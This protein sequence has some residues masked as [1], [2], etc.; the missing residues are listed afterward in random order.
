MWIYCPFNHEAFGFIE[1]KGLFSAIPPADPTTSYRPFTGSWRVDLITLLVSPL[2]KFVSFTTATLAP[3]LGF[4]NAVLDASLAN[5]DLSFL[6]FDIPAADWL[7]EGTAQKVDFLFQDLSNLTRMKIDVRSQG[8]PRMGIE[9][10][11]SMELPTIG[12]WLKISLALLGVL[13]LMWCMAI[14]KMCWAQL[15]KGRF[16]E[17][18]SGDFENVKKE[19]AK[20]Q[21]GAEIQSPSKV[22]DSG[23]RSG[24]SSR[25]ARLLCWQKL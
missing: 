12:W 9:L 4:D 17:K 20:A 11:E 1:G 15:F 22:G 5:L 19:L 14:S 25:D 21:E 10:S 13:Q 7:G 3:L 8:V 2:L 24:R 6:A 18:L 23:F 16:E